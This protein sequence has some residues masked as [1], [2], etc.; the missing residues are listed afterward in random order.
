MITPEKLQGI[1]ARFESIEQQL[2][3]PEVL[4]DPKRLQELSREHAR[5]R[6][7]LLYT[8]PSPRDS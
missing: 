3:E 6:T 4:R 7:C 8:S 2:G 5:L 1:I